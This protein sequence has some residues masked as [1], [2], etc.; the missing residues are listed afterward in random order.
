MREKKIVQ[1]LH[2]RGTIT[3]ERLSY[4]LNVSE[5]TLRNDIKSLLREARKHGF[6]IF[7]QRGEGYCLTVTD[8]AAFSAYLEGDE[9]PFY[10]DDPG[11]RLNQI[12][13]VLL[14][15]NGCL[16]IDRLA[17]IL[18]V[19]RSTMIRDLDSVEKLARDAK[20]ALSK[21]TYYGLKL[22]G[23][24]DQ[25]R[26][27]LSDYYK[28]LSSQTNFNPAM[29]D[30]IKKFDTADADTILYE[31][32]K[33]SSVN[34]NEISLRDI[35]VYLKVMLSRVSSGN[36]LRKENRVVNET[37]FRN[38]KQVAQGICDRLSAV[39]AMDIP[40]DEVN[41][42]TAHIVGK[43]SYLRLDGDLKDGLVRKI[44]DFLTKIDAIYLTD[45]SL[46]D[47]L[48]SALALHLYPL[49]NRLYNNLNLNNP[50][51]DEVNIRYTDALDVAIKFG[52]MLYEEYGFSL[53][54]DEISFIALH[55]AAH[56]ERKKKKKL[57]QFKRIAVLCTSGG[58]SAYL[59]KLSL[60]SLFYNA[61]IQ[62]FS[63]IQK[64]QLAE[65]NFDLILTIVPLPELTLK[66]PVIRIKELLDSKELG[67]IQDIIELGIA[68]SERILTT[69]FQVLEPLFSP[70]LF[71]AGCKQTNYQEL[72]ISKSEELI[73]QNK[74]AANFTELVLERERLFST[75]YRNFV[76]APHPI[77]MC[78][79]ENS[80][81][82][83]ILDSPIDW[84]GKPV[85]LVFLI[86]LK[87]GELSLHKEISELI[88]QVLEH[89]DLRKRIIASNTFDDF[90]R[91][92]SRLI[93]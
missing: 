78:A 64:D 85:Q 57:S 5:R 13:F 50:L 49:L 34:I 29:E 66:C 38:Y 79:Q 32:L 8:P 62:T 86:S 74:V 21:K 72:L 20:L 82:V 51:I 16:T 54:S 44:Q 23:S 28:E 33:K 70:A 84:N 37:E 88:F 47:E 53:S 81:S 24:E 48:L 40:E 77:E 59:L 14:A 92:V 52:E 89:D 60:E 45:F 3:I 35:A 7:N 80:I 87:K 4:L 65:G 31:E 73:R 68:K 67:R 17:E 6:Q 18:G 19:S 25:Y 90:I 30:Y 55:L 83:T 61:D 63:I 76:A 41:C 93:K 75:A 56:T 36:Y 1:E 12:M 69:R 42:L 71:E 10:N 91:R 11:A 9:E 2:G 15:H 39:L 22:V 58:G 43:S 27:V 26:T 46:D